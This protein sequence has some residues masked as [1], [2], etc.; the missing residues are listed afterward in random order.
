MPWEWQVE[1]YQWISVAGVTASMRTEV[2]VMKGQE[3]DEASLHT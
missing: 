2:E 1:N 3:V